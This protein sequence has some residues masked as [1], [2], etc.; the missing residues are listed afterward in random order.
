[1]K[2]FN[3]FISV[4]C[5]LT[6]FWQDSTQILIKMMKTTKNYQNSENTKFLW[7]YFNV[8]DFGHFRFLNSDFRRTLPKF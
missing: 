3:V 6:F 5:F 4:I 2:Y 1:M 8:F 7:K